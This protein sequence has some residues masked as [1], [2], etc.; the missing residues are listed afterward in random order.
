ML[1]FRLELDLCRQLKEVGFP[2][3]PHGDSVVYGYAKGP[4]DSEYI[5]RA[6]AHPQ[7]MDGYDFIRCPS[8]EAL[9][10][11]MANQWKFAQPTKLHVLSTIAQSDWAHGDSLTAQLALFYINQAK[12]GDN[13]DQR[14]PP[15][16]PRGKLHFVM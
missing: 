14:S 9:L 1:S 6:I 7:D 11:V 16:K 12:A 5:P 13:L 8:A 2:Q 10:N 15:R 3:F 4:H